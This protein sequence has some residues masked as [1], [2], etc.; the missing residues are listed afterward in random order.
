MYKRNYRNEGTKEKGWFSLISG[1]LGGL[2]GGSVAL[3]L[4]PQ[5]GTELRGMLC[6]YPSRT[7]K[8]LLERAEEAF[9][10]GEE[11]V[12][13]AGQSAKQF[14][15]QGSETVGDAGGSAKEYAEQTQY[16]FRDPER[17]GL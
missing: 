4:A 2:I 8:D 1:A 9:D 11:V 6:N 3:L 14:A 15:P 7:N 13:D 12:L 5:S 16:M 10:K 17:S